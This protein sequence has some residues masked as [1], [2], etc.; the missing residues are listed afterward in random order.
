MQASPFFS[1][2]ADM[3]QTFLTASLAAG[4]V[5]PAAELAQPAGS[6]PWSVEVA[7]AWLLQ[8]HGEVLRRLARSGRTTRSTG[9]TAASLG[10]LPWRPALPRRG[11]KPN[12]GGLALVC[13]DG[14]ALIAF[15]RWS[16]S[17]YVSSSSAAPDLQ[18]ARAR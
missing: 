15:T 6:Q 3:S 16:E 8:S 11:W 17:P 7:A 9:P 10:R 14:E 4:L 1:K 2:G 5:L 12:T 18:L 13:A